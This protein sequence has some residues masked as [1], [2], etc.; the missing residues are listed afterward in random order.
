MKLLTSVSVISSLSF[1]VLAIPT[2][3]PPRRQPAQPRHVENH[4]PLTLRN[5]TASPLHRRQ[6]PEQVQEVNE[7]KFYVADITLGASQQPFSVIFD[8]GSSDLWLP[9]ANGALPGHPAV[10]TSDTSISAYNGGGVACSKGYGPQNRMVSGTVYEA[11]YTIA[12]TTPTNA[13]C[14]VDSNGFGADA[15]GIIGMGPCANSGV[16]AATGD[17]GNCP[18]LA[19]GWDSFGCYLFFVLLR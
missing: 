11:Q 3:S 14:L 17:Q 12:G 2:S 16:S 6:S 4:I 15:D 5:A 10:D 19:L 13:F 8:T 7:G 1:Q 9:S 18:L